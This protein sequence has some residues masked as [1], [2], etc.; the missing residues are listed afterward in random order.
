MFV[1]NDLLSALQWYVVA[2]GKIFF[3][4]LYGTGGFSA[5]SGKALLVICSGYSQFT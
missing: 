3:L 1:T 2:K 4:S 5:A